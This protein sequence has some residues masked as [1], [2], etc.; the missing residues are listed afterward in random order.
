[1]RTLERDAQPENVGFAL[2]RPGHS[3]A[4]ITGM[5]LGRRTAEVESK[6]ELQARSVAGDG[7]K[8]FRGFPEAAQTELL[9]MPEGNSDF[10]RRTARPSC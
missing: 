3:P 9:S 8:R 7:E 10:C 5:T 1:M 2:D 4:E 6:A